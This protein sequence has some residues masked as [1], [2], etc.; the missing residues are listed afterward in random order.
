MAALVPISEWD[1]D[2]YQFR[3]PVKSVK[4]IEMLGQTGWKVRATLLR[5]L[6]DDSE[7]DLDIIITSKVWKD[8]SP[9]QIGDDIE[10]TLWLQGYLWYP[11]K[12]MADKPKG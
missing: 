10:G 1:S 5:H 8:K 4:E 11:E 12:Y 3:G 2:D 7:S 9:P 6:S